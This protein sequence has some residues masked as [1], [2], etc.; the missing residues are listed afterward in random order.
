MI[1]CFGGARC[2]ASWRRQLWVC[3]MGVLSTVCKKTKREGYRELLRE[4]LFSKVRIVRGYGDW[5]DDSCIKTA[6]TRIAT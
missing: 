1:A 2:A 4:R 5:S 3:V 6:C